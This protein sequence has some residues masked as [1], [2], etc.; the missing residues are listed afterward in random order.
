MSPVHVEDVA[1]AFDRALDDASTISK[2]LSLGG[3]ETL[4]WT[5]MLTR[6]AASVGRRKWII[7]MPL[8]VMQLVAATLDWLPFF[9]V[10]RDQLTM[11]ATGNTCDA[12]EL[13]ALIGARPRSFTNEN[14][15]YLGRKQ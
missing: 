14:L 11:L 2:T 4:S 6:I 5:E 1:L 8:G 15:A 7:P 9:P 12:S 3:P 10:T 13:E